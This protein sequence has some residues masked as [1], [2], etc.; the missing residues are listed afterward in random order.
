MKTCFKCHAQKPL[1]EFYRHPQMGDGH[2]GKCKDCTKRDTANRHAF[3]SKNPDWVDKELARHRVKS[4][5]YR[6]LGGAS[7]S[8]KE[9]RDKWYKNNKQKKL[10]HGVIQRAI[11]SG[12]MSRLPCEVCG[13]KNSHGHHDDYSRPLNVNW[14]CPKHHGER[15]VELNRIA[16]RSNLDT[17]H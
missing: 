14:L 13:A 6:L 7:K 11:Q 5:K 10:A 4:A 17:A 3:L 9:S 16:R 1:S 2:L 8:S 12:L 15:H